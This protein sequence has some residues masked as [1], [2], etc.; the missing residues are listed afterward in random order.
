M[1]ERLFDSQSMEDENGLEKK[2]YQYV[3]EFLTKRKFNVTLAEAVL[4]RQI[5]KDVYINEPKERGKYLKET[6]KDPMSSTTNKL[7]ETLGRF[8][9]QY[10]GINF[11]EYIDSMKEEYRE[12]AIKDFFK[13]VQEKL[14][15]DREL[16]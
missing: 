5:V 2:F 9:L 13:Y 11:L 12:D 16:I 15:N 8:F 7:F 10:Y 6:G 4:L 1:K 3:L 14:R